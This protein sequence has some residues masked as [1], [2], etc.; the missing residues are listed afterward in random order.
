MSI[1]KMKSIRR[2]VRVLVSR[3]Q[4]YLRFPIFGND[5]RSQSYF[6]DQQLFD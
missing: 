1:G 3:E 4:Q 2:K 6:L 5:C